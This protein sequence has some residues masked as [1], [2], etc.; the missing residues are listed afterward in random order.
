MLSSR[1]AVPGTVLAAVLVTAA[2]TGAQT[3]VPAARFITY[4]ELG[5]FVRGLKGKVVVVDF[6]ADY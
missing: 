2:A 5:K 1:R 4:G 3:G 6:W